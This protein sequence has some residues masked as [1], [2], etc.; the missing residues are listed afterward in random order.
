M[1]DCVGG[2]GDWDAPPSDMQTWLTDNGYPLTV[3]CPDKPTCRVGD[4]E[5]TVDY[6]IVSP[7]ILHMN[8]DVAVFETSLATHSPVRMRLRLDGEPQLT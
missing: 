3:V 4:Q 5:S 7:R 2:G 6:F 8:E 1:P